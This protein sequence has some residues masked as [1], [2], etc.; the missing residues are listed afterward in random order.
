MSSRAQRVVDALRQRGQTFA[1]A[2]SLTGGLIGATVTEV[3]GASEVY[4]GGLVT[5]QT[6]MKV[7]LLGVP[8]SIIDQDTVVSAAVAREMSRRVVELTAADW[9]IAVTGVAGPTGQEGHAPGEVWIGVA[10]PHVPGGVRAVGQNFT[11]DR[12]AVRERTVDAALE[13]LLRSLQPV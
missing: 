11:G 13:V 5:Y 6:A 3:P 10:G 4:R 9:G 8:A 1:T 2:E 7:L 12:A